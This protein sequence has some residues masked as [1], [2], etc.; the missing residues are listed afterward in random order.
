[1]VRRKDGFLRLAEQE[2][3]LK[4]T[5][6][7]Q[8]TLK[9]PEGKGEEVIKIAEKFE[10]KNVI[11]IPQEDADL[12]VV[13]LRNNKVGDFLQELDD[14]TEAEITF[15]PR[16]IITLVP[17]ASETPDQVK[18]VGIKSP[19]EIFLSGIQSVGS[20]KGF[21][22]YA[23]SAG[24]VVWIGLYAQT[25]YL[26][27]AS[28]L[29]APFAGPAMNAALATSA[30]EGSLLRKSIK[31]YFIALIVTIA[32]SALLT[33]IMGQQ[34][35]TS[36]MISVSQLSAVS[37]FLPLIA[38]FAGALNLVQAER[39]SL[40][41]GAAVGVLVAASLAPP[42]GVLGMSLAM[43]NWTLAQSGI[44]LLFLQLIGINLS[45]TMVFRFYGDIDVKGARFQNGKRK[46]FWSSMGVSAVALVGLLFWQFSD[47]PELLKS[48]VDSE[49]EKV[50]KNVL[51]NFDG[52]EVIE[53]TARF[54][55]GNAQGA[56]PILIELDLVRKGTG[57][58]LS[59]EELKEQ[60]T[61]TISRKVKEKFPNVQP[62][63][64]IT[65]L[66]AGPE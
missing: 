31:R 44:F 24:V 65:F 25:M 26:L 9:V 48:S 16:G 49:V 37:V 34:Y 29:I 6:M 47:S 13:H 56:E 61:S 43:G 64:N 3:T 39:D 33:L 32:T 60:I 22:G 28:M 45:A 59:D 51:N 30:G 57:N 35:A 38:G 11:D 54:T 21:I 4:Q 50:S 12:V 23:I 40:V 2:A 53:A 42:A 1:M 66:M 10:A 18:E 20:M 14:L 63:Y 58:N 8:L 62:V 17:P 55:R 7:R 19:I 46:V 15:I 5:H 41:S 27:T 52:V 36:L